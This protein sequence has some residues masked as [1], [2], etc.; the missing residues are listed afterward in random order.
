MKTIKIF[1]IA[2]LAIMC[3]S[4]AYAAGLENE[5]AQ[6]GV[7]FGE[8][9]LAGT[10]PAVKVGGDFAPVKT[11][12]YTAGAVKTSDSATVPPPVKATPAI[13]KGENAGIIAGVVTGAVG[14]S[15]LTW[16]L[17]AAVWGP[18]GAAV[19]AIAAIVVVTFV[20]CMIGGYIGKKI[21][22]LFDKK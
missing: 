3:G 1:A 11:A 5:R 15:I 7:K 14:A 6:S 4:A 13:G 9:A 2:A 8:S 21:G 10:A 22:S 18:I 12:A 17:A 19:L 20:C 16:G